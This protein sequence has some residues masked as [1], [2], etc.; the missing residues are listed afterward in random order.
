MYL[1]PVTVAEIANH[2]GKYV[3]FDFSDGWDNYHEEGYLLAI[4]E[5]TADTEYRTY[6]HVSDEPELSDPSTD[7]H[8]LGGYGLGLKDIVYV[9][10]R[11]KVVKKNGLNQ[12]K[13][14][15]ATLGDIT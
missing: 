3:S 5:P 9:G 7:P 11:P 13:D 4:T 12:I 14:A 10:S 1:K 15:I 6:L 8:N 2:I